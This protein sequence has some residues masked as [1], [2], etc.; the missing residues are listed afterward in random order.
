[1]KLKIGY[2]SKLGKLGMEKLFSIYL[3]GVGVVSASKRDNDGFEFFELSRLQLRKFKKKIEKE[4]EKDNGK[5]SI[6][7]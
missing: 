3:P 5:E 1:M 6:V 2:V 7:E 4:L